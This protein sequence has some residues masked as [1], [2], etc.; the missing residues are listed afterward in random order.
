MTIASL[1]KSQGYR[2]AMPGNGISA[3]GRMATTSPARRTGDVPIRNVFRPARLH[4]HPAVFFFRVDRAVTPPTD[5]IE[6]HHSPMA[7]SGSTFIA[8]PET[9]THRE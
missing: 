6:A 7:V 5:H 2:T 9:S 8:R 4:G 1:L 3:F